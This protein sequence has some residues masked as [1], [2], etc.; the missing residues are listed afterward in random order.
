[1]TLVSQASLLS[2]A[3]FLR[4][5]DPLLYP[6]YLGNIRCA[7]SHVSPV[8]PVSVESSESLEPPEP[9]Y[10]PDLPECYR[11]ISPL[12]LPMPPLQPQSPPSPPPPS[13]PYRLRGRPR[14]MAPGPKPKYKRRKALLTEDQKR[15]YRTYSRRK[16]AET[17]KVEDYIIMRE[18][19]LEKDNARL[20]AQCCVLR[21]KVAMLC[22]RVRERL[23]VK[24]F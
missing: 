15:R 11:P 2:P 16:R 10:P 5:D 21:E 3:F 8:S 14:V 6:D 19:Q 4:H 17:R 12:P 20:R 18:W 22:G 24:A 13:P 23:G 9:L 1:M 7:R